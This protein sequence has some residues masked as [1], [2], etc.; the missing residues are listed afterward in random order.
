MK[1]NEQR[2]ELKGEYHVNIQSEKGILKRQIW[3]VQ[4]EGRFGDIKENERFWRFHYR[5]SEKV[6]KELMLYAIGWN[7]NKYYRFLYQEIEKYD[8][9]TEKKTT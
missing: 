5:T 1:T 7:I 9:K 8:E 2:E 4:T 3:T 6:Y